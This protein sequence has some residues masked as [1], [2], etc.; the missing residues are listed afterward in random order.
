MCLRAAA[1]RCRLS[2]SPTIN[3]SRSQRLRQT[4]FQVELSWG[5]AH[6]QWRVPLAIP[7]GSTLGDA[8]FAARLNESIE[9]RPPTDF[10]AAG[11]LGQ[12]CA[13]A[14][15]LRS[16]DRIE[17]YRPLLADP[18]DARRARVSRQRGHQEID[19]AIKPSHHA[20]H[21]PSAPVTALKR[22]LAAAPVRCSSP[23]CS[24]SVAAAWSCPWPCSSG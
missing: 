2:P 15:R 5:D 11:I 13:P 7:A 1:T 4:Q 10:V 8:L 17:L 24:R 23:P 14:T 3:S 20:I 19:P 16:G 18:K 9:L 22:T 12:R 21:A 6:R